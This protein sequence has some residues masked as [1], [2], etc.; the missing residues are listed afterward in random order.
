MLAVLLFIAASAVPPQAPPAKVAALERIVV[1][2]ASLSHGY[3]LEQDGG[4]RVRFAD[5]VETSLRAAHAPVLPRTS[6]FFFTDPQGTGKSLAATARSADPTLVV[7]IDYLF[8]FGYGACASPDG[9]LELL[10]RGLALLDEFHCPVMV[11]DFP[12][13]R[14]A[15][16]DPA[17]GSPPRLLAPEQVPSPDELRKLN[18]HLRAWASTRKNVVVVPL[19]DLGARLRSGKDLE[20]HGNHWAG[21]TLAGLMQKDRLHPTLDG[22]IALWLGA[23][24][25]LVAARPDVPA[26]A[27]DW[28]A[29]AIRKR[30]CDSRANARVPADGGR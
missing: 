21:G 23:L 22:A 1:L 7:A 17:P 5:V 8:W 27:F 24:D 30:I 10:D 29:Q 25:A 4:G 20:I 16:R 26:S 6:L 2:G 28:D 18:D 11:G 3:G 15:S 9:R 14:E 13:C 12:D 19:A